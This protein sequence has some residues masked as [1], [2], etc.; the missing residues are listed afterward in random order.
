MLLVKCIEN[1]QIATLALTCEILLFNFKLAIVHSSSQLKNM[2]NPFQNLLKE[3][4]MHKI[5]LVTKM[6]AMILFIICETAT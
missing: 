6:N 5:V 1:N 4:V 2:A 3:E